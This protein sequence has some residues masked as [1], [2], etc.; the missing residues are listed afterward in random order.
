MKHLLTVFLAI[1]L[2][3]LIVAPS[4]VFAASD[5]LKVYASDG[6]LD[7]V[8]RADT[9]P[10]GS[11]AH[12]VYLLMSTDTTYIFDAT[13]TVKSSVAFIGVPK[14]GTGQLPC[15]QPDVLG[16]LSI[17][18]LL[19]TLTGNHTT[20]TFKNLYLLGIAVNNQVNFGGGQAI[21]LTADS[22]TIVTDNCVYEQ[23]SQFAI[24]YAGSYCKFFITNCK[25]RNMTTQPNQ[26]YVGEA[27]RNE[28]YIAAFKT[29]SIVMKNNTLLCVSGYATAATGGIVNYYEFS[30]NNF[31]YSFKNPFFL[32]RMVNAKFNNNIFY[33]VYAGGQS[34]TEFNGGWD[35]F[36]AGTVASIITM[37][38][39]DSATAAI[40]LGH[41]STGAGDTTAEKLRKV[42]VK[43]NAY[44][45]P[46][47]LVSYWTAW[48]DTAHVDSIYTPVW[49]NA[50]SVNMF[51]D[52]A[53]W[54][55]FVESGNQSVDPGFG[56]S[57]PGV[58]QAGTGNANGVGL[59]AWFAAVR[60]GTGTSETYGYNFTQVENKA[61]WVPPWPLPEA[62]DMQYSN[63]A[64]KTGATDGKEVGDPYWWVGGPSAVQP[65][66]GTAPLSYSLSQNYPNPFNPST[67]ITYSVPK[68]GSVQLSIYNTLGQKVATLVN[69]VVAAGQHTVTFSA[70]NLA[71]GVYF[72]RIEAGSYTATMKMTL[73]K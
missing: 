17:P 62:T 33:G 4:Q 14:A 13:I 68:S 54:P 71:S 52:H 3:G 29:D 53:K 11:Q 57:I 51:T 22:A 42:E 25:F 58:L 2:V 67:Q 31:V 55:G 73:L 47:A 46:S 48:N 37:G 70:G 69:G 21:Q 60:G 9:L 12:S 28:N 39:L 38:P 41:A 1:A 20:G 59:L 36:T 24:G 26:Y 61:S 44:F 23:W 40:L 32:D 65:Q 27:L 43:N 8:V 5:T 10:N 66:P 35:S 49:M 45:W 18:G 16:D 19:F 63:T 6:L 72:Y 56:A 7:Q 64:L 34:K 15:I 50:Q 30:H